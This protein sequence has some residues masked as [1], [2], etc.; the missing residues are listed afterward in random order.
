MIDY[1]M[2]FENYRKAEGVSQSGLSLLKKSPAHYRFDMDNPRAPTPAMTFG[3]AFHSYMLDAD[4]TFDKKYAVMQKLDRRTTAGKKAAAEF[5]EANA[6]KQVLSEED[7]AAIQGMSYSLEK[8]DAWHVA[9]GQQ[10]EVS[11]FWKDYA[12]GVD[13][14]GRLDGWNSEKQVIFDIKTCRDASPEG[15][16][17]S[18][19]TFRYYGQGAYYMEGAKQNGLS[20]RHFLIYAVET[21]APYHCACYRLL[22][23]ILTIGQVENDELLKRYAYCKANDTWPGY[24][25]SIQ[26]IGLPQWMSSRLEATYGKL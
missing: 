13:C 12:N 23:E 26:D 7:Y 9:S 17:K 21:E 4:K 25:K 6:G 2:S 20:P 24:P 18:I 19:A 1:E 10:C 14:K 15:F 8:L 16:A 11:L 5:E 22:D 3:S